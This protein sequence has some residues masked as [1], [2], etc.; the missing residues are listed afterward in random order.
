MAVKGALPEPT[1]TIVCEQCGG[2]SFNLDKVPAV[3]G[4]DEVAFACRVARL[5]P[6]ALD[7]LSA[8]LHEH[9]DHAWS[10]CS[11]EPLDNYRKRS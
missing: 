10:L 4:E 9:R 3:E 7:G 2:A 6:E 8:F 1:T 5:Q 11:I